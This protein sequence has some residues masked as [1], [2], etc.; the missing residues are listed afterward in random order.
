M[1]TIYLVRHG[2]AEGNA[3]RRI[4]GQYD[5]NLTPTG[6]QQAQCVKNRFETIHL[7]AVISSDLTRAA[8]TA[9][10]LAEAKGLP[11][12]LDPAFREA[13][14]G[15]WE[16]V[17]FGYLEGFEAQAMVDFSWDPQHWQVEGSEAFE[18]YTDR[19]IHGM[20]RWADAYPDGTI[21]I[22]CHSVILRGILLRLFF[23]D[24]IKGIPYC[25]NTA[26]SKIFYENGAFSYEFLNNA[27]HVPPHLSTYVKQK[28]WRDSR[29]S[30][31]DFNLWY[32]PLAN[33]PAL[34]QEIAA[35]AE[36][37]R[38]LAL[39]KG[40]PEAAMVAM[41]RNT[42]VGLVSIDPQKGRLD[43]LY[44]KEAQ[45]GKFMDDQLLGQAVMVVRRLG[46][47]QMEVDL[48]RIPEPELAERYH[49]TTGILDLRVRILNG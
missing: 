48:A 43:A 40:M 44:L 20:R 33:D 21:A 26:V 15:R 22:F 12:Q 9:A 10:P 28:W 1:T 23:P 4:H 5:S 38:A 49:F 14:L 42:P 24:N 45:R 2:E 6:R 19:F 30:K 41:L 8:S 7:D 18:T 11:P 3:F 31:R 32:Q 47:S 25:E 29:L 37:D 27:D 16:D 35:P 34:A 17:P 39:A 13:C 36:T 46:F